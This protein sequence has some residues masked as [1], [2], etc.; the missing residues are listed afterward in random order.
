[1]RRAILSGAAVMVSL[2]VL[3]AAASSANNSPAVVGTGITHCVGGWTGV[4]TFGL[5]LL[6]G[7]TASTEEVSLTAI[8]RPC[9]GG[10]PTPTK[11]KFVGKGIINAAGANDCNNFFATPAPPGG[12]DVETFTPFFGGAISWS[13]P[14]ISSSLLSLTAMDVITSSLASPVQFKAPV[15]TVTNSYATAAG[16]FK[17]KTT[18]L[19]GTI[20]SNSVGDCGS[21]SGLSQVTIAAAGSNGKF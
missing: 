2:I 11:G 17:F 13:P 8:V 3:P 14:S 20:L 4:V 1:M 15:V 21:T 5:A 10:T 12:T 19:L 6:T 18:Q 16:K 7:G 9:A